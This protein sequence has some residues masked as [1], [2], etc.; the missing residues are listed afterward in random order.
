MDPKQIANQMIQF[1]KTA[2]DNTFN[3]MTVLQEQTEKMV[4]MFLEQQSPW[5]PAEGKKAVTDWLKAY[6]RGREEFKATV[7]DNY[8]KVEEYFAGAD[9]GKVED[10]FVNVEKTRKTKAGK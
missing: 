6:K 5:M 10:F 4:N 8:R 9:K 3:A 1:N 7:D 2:F